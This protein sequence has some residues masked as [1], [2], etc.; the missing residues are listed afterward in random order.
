[1]TTSVEAVVDALGWALLHS[2][3]QLSILAGLAVLL[4][5]LTAFPQ[6]LLLLQ[7]PASTAAAVLTPSTFRLV[8]ST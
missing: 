3:W 6:L 5:A 8:L 4:T 1:M 2:T 7:Q